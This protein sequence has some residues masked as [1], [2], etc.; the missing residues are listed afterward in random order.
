[1]QWH[2]TGS[3]RVAWRRGEGSGGTA[4]RRGNEIDQSIGLIGSIGSVG[5][6]GDR[7]SSSRG[8]GVP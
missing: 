4:N 1:M 3:R 7:S 2:P 8:R 6:L 5:S